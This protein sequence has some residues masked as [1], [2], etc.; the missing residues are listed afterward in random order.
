LS[1]ILLYAA[2]LRFDALFKSY[3]PY[4]EP[5]WLAALQPAV[6][7]IAS[8]LTPDWS[9]RHIEVPY[10]GGDPINYLKYA[11][12]MQQFYAAH[13]R[14][15]GFPA[16]TRLALALSGDEDVG[17]SIASITFALL[18]IV[19]TYMLGRQMGSPIV[20]L[21]AALA[22]AIDARAVIWSVGGWRDE[23]FAFFAVL[24]AWAWLRLAQHATYDRALVAGLASGGALLTRITSFALLVPPIVFLLARQDRDRLLPHVALA[25]GIMLAAIA[26]FMIN[27]AI[28]TGDPLYAINNHTDF[29]LKR[30]GVAN[31]DPIS[32]VAYTF[33]KFARPLAATDTMVAGVF[34]YPFNNK[35]VGLDLWYQGLGRVLSWLAIAGLAAWLWHRD[36]RF[37]LFMFLGSLIPFSATWTV[38]GGAE[39]RLT[40][41]AY[42]FYLIAAFWVLLTIVRR[43]FVWPGSRRAA[44]IALT[45]VMLA[46]AGAAWTFA[47]PYA[48]AR[49]SLGR[50]E[51]VM[52]RADVRDRLMMTDGWSDL[53]VTQ[54]VTARFTTRPVAAIRLPLPVQRPYRIVL[55]IDPLHDADAPPQ[56]VQVALNGQHVATL[57]LGWNPERVGEY[58]VD[59]PAAAVR[60]GSN[61]LT[62]RAERMVPMTRAGS[63]Y[64]E[65]S[66]DQEVGFR[67]W[68]ML[69][70]PD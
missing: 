58:S 18:A 60:R 12:Q 55:R 56:R 51:A 40:L 24:S 65:I 25:A 50:G 33:G 13:V 5:R 53:V 21:A 43:Q 66:R 49:E 32:A 39:W 31:P 20:G 69:V 59:V 17:V 62:F 38:R 23:M 30:E 15:P 36:G 7:A 10:V 2:V 41:F 28:A 64:P 4:E 16:A 63:A 34:A 29:Y 11:R 1:C 45:V 3:G 70:T 35:W 46:L 26:P 14:E 37:L 57:Q 52:V 47:M 54:N 27:C 9:W 61:E 67:F 68:Y 22:L 42:S 8:T 19:A 48:I 6:R 44:S